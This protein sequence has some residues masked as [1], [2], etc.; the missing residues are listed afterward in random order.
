MGSEGG[1]AVSVPV[2]VEDECISTGDE[3]DELP[4]VADRVGDM[5]RRRICG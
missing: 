2:P 4:P 1:V 3:D 5:V